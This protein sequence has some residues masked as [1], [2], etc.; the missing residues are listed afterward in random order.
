[1]AGAPFEPLP[2][3][4]HIAPATKELPTAFTTS[5]DRRLDDQREANNPGAR[6]M[7]S[8]RSAHCTVRGQR[9]F[10][11]AQDPVQN[12]NASTH[13][14][15]EANPEP[16]H[17]PF[18]LDVASLECGEASQKSQS[19]QGLSAYL[20]FR[21]S[22]TPRDHLKLTLMIMQNQSRLTTRCSPCAAKK[23]R[24]GHCGSGTSA[25]T[26]LMDKPLPMNAAPRSTTRTRMSLGPPS[27][28]SRARIARGTNGARPQGVG[29]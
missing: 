26:G 1:M 22:K 3:A 5:R 6:I 18:H 15:P 16:H 23:M 10:P 4:S 8:H 20:D 27:A 9:G 7:S 28:W 21:F 12:L 13:L 19:N 24:H 29:R 11:C 14:A 17:A 25:S 2:N